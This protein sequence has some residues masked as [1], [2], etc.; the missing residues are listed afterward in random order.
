[1]YSLC[2]CLEK[3]IC[4]NIGVKLLNLEDVG[5]PKASSHQPKEEVYEHYEYIRKNKTLF[6]KIKK[7]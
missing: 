6:E 3:N 7:H 2:K 5:V 4:Q 1:M